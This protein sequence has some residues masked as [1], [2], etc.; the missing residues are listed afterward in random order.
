VLSGK[1][2]VGTETPT[3]KLHISDS[4]SGNVLRLEGSGTFGS[5]A[6][7]NFGDVDFV[8]LSEDIDDH[9]LI[10]AAGRIALTSSSVGVG[11]TLPD[12]SAAL[13]VN[14]TTRG[15]LPPRMSEAE[16]DAISNAVA[17]LTIWCNNCGP[18]GELQVYNGAKWVNMVGKAS[19]PH[20][21]PTVTDSEG[22]T[23]NTIIIGGQCW[24]AE[25]LNTGA[26]INGIY[27]Q[28]SNQPIEKYCY[29][30]DVANCATYGG[31]YQWDEMMQYVTTEG[32]QGICPSGWHIPTDT[33]W[34]TL[35]LFLGMTQSKSNTEGL[36]ETNNEGGKL[37]ETGTLNWDTPNAGAQDL[38]GF[39]AI[40]GGYRHKSGSFFNLFNVCYFWLSSETPNVGAWNR[41]LSKDNGG[42]YRSTN[43]D[44]KSGYS[45]RCVKD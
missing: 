25:N 1:V 13:E 15:F 3:H 35:E 21:E 30:D 45:V 17:G 38:Y 8:Y 33:E 14:S 5:E 43:I 37:K 36:R 19:A 41:Q 7:L 18:S 4:T 39:T 20:C 10:H 16:R 12:A 6:K 28:T 22:H 23:Y 26:F 9:L 42:I 34:K 27:D 44:K 11:T 29:N 2:G 32:T 31:L 40:P 24:M